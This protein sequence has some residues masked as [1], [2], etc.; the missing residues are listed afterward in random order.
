MP[1]VAQPV[2][3]RAATAVPEAVVPEAVVPEA[4]VPEAVVPADA[5]WAAVQ[6]G[7]L[8]DVTGRCAYFVATLAAASAIRLANFHRWRR[9]DS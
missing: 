9:C 4:A 3:M 7:F 2:P 6:P 5:E 1:T 8:L